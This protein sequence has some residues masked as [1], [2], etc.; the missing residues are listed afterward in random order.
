MEK[1]F[2]VGQKIQLPLILLSVSIT[3]GL[4]IYFS[5]LLVS[6]INERFNERI[7]QSSAFV[8]LGLS[9]SLGTGNMQGAKKTI[10]NFADDKE[11]AFIYLLDEENQF[12]MKHLDPDAFGIKEN[13]L[14]QINNMIP[15]ELNDI[16]IKKSELRYEDNFLGT[17][18]IA[19]KTESRR[20]S[21][22]TIITSSIIGILVMVSLSV[23]LNTL[24]VRKVLTAP[25]EL[26][27][28][29]LKRL[30]EGDL[31]TKMEC[32]T[33]DEF[34]DLA[35][36]LDASIENMS[37]MLNDIK[38]IGSENSQVSESLSHTAK[39]MISMLSE[40]GDIVRSSAQRGQEI[41]E[42]LAE[43]L[44]SAEHTNESMLKVEDKLS[45]AKNGVID[46][47]HRIKK[48]TEV[49]LEM[50]ASLDQLS[51]EA[52]QIKDVLTVIADIADQTNLLALNA[53][54]EA[55][56]AG[57][58]GRGF[59]VVAD[60]VRKLAE[61]TQK[62]LTEINATINVIVQSIMDSSGKMNSNVKFV[63][64]L[65]SISNNVEDEI[66]MTFNIVNKTKAT[67][68]QTYEHTKLMTSNTD[69]LIEMI[70]EA[71]QITQSGLL[72]IDNINA[73]SNKLESVSINL[74]NKLQ[75]FKT[76]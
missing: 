10:E 72:S 76:K 50:A 44:S 64:E 60:E 74:I 42:M 59:A 22:N 69:N 21:I 65:Y 46:M 7:Y 32:N 52:T 47:V 58:H 25:L 34:E 5:N 57:E 37:S 62:S 36:Y 24:V 39:D 71:D 17:Y 18:F 43:F 26:F 33:K 19:Y 49:E 11:L 45:E 61:R 4:I 3:I 20:D 73:V 12:F 53:A 14:L 48:S 63:N 15:V 70:H 27:I 56:R 35:K 13:D 8:N 16:L 75:L 1:N 31:M 29:S 9:L 55:A 38:H 2:S 6:N 30:A 54:I 28:L 41:K 66:N 40:S 68:E 23:F 67:S 51:S